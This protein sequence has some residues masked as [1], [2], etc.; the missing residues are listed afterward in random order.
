MFHHILLPRVMEELNRVRLVG[1]GSVEKNKC[2]RPVHRGE[3]EAKETQRST[4]EVHWLLEASTR[5][6]TGST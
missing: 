1:N 5:E 2:T 3:A 6:D 4:R